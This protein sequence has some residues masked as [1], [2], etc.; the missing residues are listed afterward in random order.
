MS[1]YEVATKLTEDLP[2]DG[3][4]ISG[5]EPLQQIEP[6]LAFLSLYQAE[7]SPSTTIIMYSGYTKDQIRAS[8]PL[9]NNLR[10]LGVD[11]IICGRYNH[12][13]A[14]QNRGLISSSNQEAF[15]LSDYFKKGELDSG[16]SGV[17]AIIGEDGEIKISGFPNNELLNT[18][19]RQS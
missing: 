14:V 4:T 1:I 6:L 2:F 19:R 18:I 15:L 12:K 7:F 13:M 5:G 16:P 10:S 17:E 3:I 8:R 9:V 11:A